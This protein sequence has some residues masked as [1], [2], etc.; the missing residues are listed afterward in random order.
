LF[1]PLLMQAHPA[2]ARAWSPD[3]PHRFSYRWRRQGLPGSWETPMPACPVLRPRRDPGVMPS[4]AKIWPSAY[5]TASALAK[6]NFRG[7]IARPT[8]SL[9]TL[10]SVGYPHAMQH[11]VPVAGTLTGRDWVPVGSLQKVSEFT[12]SSSSRLALAHCANIPPDIHP[13]HFVLR[14]TPPPNTR[15]SRFCNS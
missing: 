9:C 2:E 15:H 13:Q 1:A 12:S 14:R 11:S 10:H 7:S 4:F 6:R 8:D 3:S 5:T